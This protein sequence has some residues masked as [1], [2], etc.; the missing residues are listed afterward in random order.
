MLSCSF[1]V[2]NGVKSYLLGVWATT[3]TLTALAIIAFLYSASTSKLKHQLN[4]NHHF[5]SSIFDRIFHK[6]ASSLGK[7][8]DKEED[9][10]QEQEQDPLPSTEY[11]SS[12]FDYHVVKDWTPSSSSSLKHEKEKHFIGINVLPPDV[13]KEVKERKKTRRGEDDDEK[14]MGFLPHSGFHNQR[15]ALQN[16]FM[17]G[18][19]L[20]RTVLLPPVWIGWPTPT[21][22]YDTLVR[23]FPLTSFLPPLSF[24]YLTQT[25]PQLIPPPPHQLQQKS[26]TSILLTTPHSFGLLP[27]PSSSPLNF[28]NPSYPSTTTTYPSLSPT[29]EEEEQSRQ[30]A[31]VQ[32]QRARDKWRALGWDVRPDGFPVTNLTERECRSYSPECRH[33]YRDS[34][35]GWGALVDLDKVRELGVRTRE[36]WDVRERAVQTLLGVGEDE[37]YILRDHQSYDLQFVHHTFPNNTFLSLST[38]KSHWAR[39]VSLPALRSH[40]S[41]VILMG[42]LF[43]SGRIHSPSPSSSME[44]GDGKTPYPFPW[45]VAEQE[46]LKRTLSEAMAFRSAW[47]MGPAGEISARL[48]G[49]GVRGYVGLHAR[50]G[51]GEFERRERWNMKIVWERLVSRLRVDR[52]TAR[53]VWERVKPVEVEVEGE[54]GGRREKRRLEEEWE[55]EDE[56]FEFEFDEDEEDDDG[57]DEFDPRKLSRRQPRSHPQRHSHARRVFPP[58]PPS[59][60]ETLKNLHCRSPLHTA[61]S[62]LL[63]NTPIYLAT[64]S[65]SPLDDPFLQPFFKAFPCVFMLS[66]FD[67]PSELNDGIVVEG[68]GEMMRLVNKLDGVPLGRLFLPFLE[69]VVAAKGRTTIGTR[70][71][72]FSSYAEGDLHRAYMADTRD[73]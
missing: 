40:P 14:F 21:E 1:R 17:L 31:L 22:Y 18:Y 28:P 32:S 6:S 15:L 50:V 53:D 13:E 25:N 49:G 11:L 54:G 68:V 71:S 33:T 16:A 37:V 36:R 4:R 47:L 65:R 62:L 39:R 64:D 8:K 55:V 51:D 52:R 58:I 29:P 41:R 24:F 26:W 23:F 45:G 30:T 34:F 67:R 2:A 61:P 27:G 59:P 42:S 38:D 12:A 44:T 66:D 57:E 43:G 56:G 48:G 69:A 60:T 19:L 63:F 5:D 70:G 73:D 35:L 10:W 20:N 72:T 46:S 3:T 9:E 7:E